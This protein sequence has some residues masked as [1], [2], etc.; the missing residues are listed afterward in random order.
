MNLYNKYILP[1]YINLVMRNKDLEKYRAGVAGGASG[2]VLEIGFGS[3]L[4][5]SY[6]KNI[7]KFYALD[8]SQELYQLAQERIKSVLFPVEYLQ[9]S[10]E[11]IPLPDNSVDS[12]VSTWTL[13]SIPNPEI[14]LKEILRVLKPSGK[15]LF[16]EHGKSPNT[17]VSKMQNLFTPISKRVAGGCHMNRDVEKLILNAGF[18]MQKLEKFYQKSRLLGLLYKGVAVV[19][20]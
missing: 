10:A 5:L 15:F 4:N 16:I 3:G 2:V 18:E 1:K 6:Y 11:I 13:C 20:K 7:N 17:L 14:A 12:V 9:A 19:E 8:P